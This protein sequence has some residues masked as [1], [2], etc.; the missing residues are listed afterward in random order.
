M[1]IAEPA[2]GGIFAFTAVLEKPLTVDPGAAAARP[3]ERP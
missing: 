1:V 2:A 3:L